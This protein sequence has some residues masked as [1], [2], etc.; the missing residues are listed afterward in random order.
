[1]NYSPKMRSQQG[2]A[3][4]TILLLVVAITIVAGSMLARQRVMVR[5]YAA[6]QR[7]GQAQQAALA[8]E[9]IAR[10]IILQDSLANQA[11]SLQEAW[12]KPLPQYP[13]TGGSLSLRI[14]DEASRFNINNLYHDGN[15]DNQALAYFRALLQAQGI[16]PEIAMAVLDWQDPDSDTMPEGGAE[17]DYYQSLGRALPMPIAN[18]PFISID[19]LLSVRG[20]DKQKLDKLR[21][22]ISVVPFFMPMNVNT[23]NPTL[24]AIIP[25][26]TDLPATAI[27]GQGNNL[28]SAPINTNNPDNTTSLLEPS[29]LASWAAARPTAMPIESVTNL[30]VQPAFA[31]VPEAQRGKVA[32]LLDVQSHAFRVVVTVTLDDSQRFFTSQLAKMDARIDP[33]NAETGANPGLNST[34]TSSQAPRVVAFNRQ[35]LAM[36]PDI[37]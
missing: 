21:P 25:S 9:A 36:A 19:E 20:M 22:L 17:S 8:G 24:L 35:F 37:N 16:E 26:V 18:Q 13:I 15:V 30:W 7:Q 3:L 14:S 28:A 6:T 4:L 11:D 10:E 23:V 1:M 5:E 12:A 32:G 34:N 27:A 31:S 2:V 33:A 29:A